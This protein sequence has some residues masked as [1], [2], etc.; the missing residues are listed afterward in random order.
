[1]KDTADPQ[2]GD[3]INALIKKYAETI[4]SNDAVALAALYTEEAVLVTPGGVFY[5]RQ[6]IEQWLIQAFQQHP[7]DFSILLT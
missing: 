4:N 3:Q 7:K 2:V 1:M 6:A 5:G